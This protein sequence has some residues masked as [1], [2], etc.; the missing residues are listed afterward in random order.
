LKSGSLTNLLPTSSELSFMRFRQF[1]STAVF[2]GLVASSGLSQA[3]TLLTFNLTTTTLGQFVTGLAGGFAAEG[4]A[5]T[6]GNAAA[7]YSSYAWTPVSESI[8]GTSS[9]TNIN[10][11]IVANV[12]AAS[13][14]T[15]TFTN[16]TNYAPF[17]A[18][19]AY[20]DTNLGSLIAGAAG[21]AVL[22]ASFANLT[23]PG[24]AASISGFPSIAALGA[25]DTLTIN[26]VSAVPEPG[27]WAMMLSGLAVVG[28]MARRRRKTLR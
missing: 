12:A 8:V 5:L 4:Y 15:V 17:L 13:G 1:I 20:L 27:E 9:V 25:N 11:T 14:G 7:A 22:A 19:D 16:P 18:L 10:A 24:A 6:P 2:S 3:A 26:L 23:L 21:N 28:A